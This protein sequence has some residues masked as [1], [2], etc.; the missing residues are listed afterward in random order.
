MKYLLSVIS[1]IIGLTSVWMWGPSNAHVFGA[2][3]DPG[4]SLALVAL[5]DSTKGGEWVHSWNLSAPVKEWYGVTLDGAGHKV[6]SLN[7]GNNGLDGVIPQAIGRLE[8]L[9][10]LRMPGNKLK[11][12]LP[13]SLTML[14]NLRQLI[15]YDNQ[16]EGS[17]PDSMQRMLS[18]KMISLINNKLNQALPASLGHL[19]QLEVLILSNNEIPGSIPESFSALV[20]LRTCNLSN[21]RLTGVLP[22]GTGQMTDLQE[23][24]LS[25]NQI[26]GKVPAS[27]AQ[28]KELRY[29]WLDHNRFMDSF[30]E[31]NLPELISLKLENNRFT[32]LPDLSIMPKLHDTAPNGVDVRHNQLS[33]ED[34][35]PNLALVDS[36]SRF[37]YWPQDTI[38][39]RDT[40][41]LTVG[42]AFRYKLPF[43]DTLSSNTYKWYKYKVQKEITRANELVFTKV[44]YSDE[45]EYHCEVSNSLLDSVKLQAYAFTLKIKGNTGCGD[46]PPADEC[47]LAKVQCSLNALDTYCAQTDQSRPRE[48]FSFCG[49]LMTLADRDW[50]AF[51]AGA[52]QARIRIT[53]FSCSSEPG[54]GIVALVFEDCSLG[55]PISCDTNCTQSTI[56]LNLTNLTVG[57]DYYLLI[58]GCE[59]GCYYQISVKQGGEGVELPEPGSIRGQDSICDHSA[60]YN[61]TLDSAIQGAVKYE[62]TVGDEAPSY[63][64]K[65]KLNTQWTEAGIFHLCVRGIGICDTTA[66][67]CRTVT[68]YPELKYENLQI[69]TVNEKQKYYVSF[70][71]TGGTPPFTVTGSSGVYNAVN[72]TFSSDLIDC[73]RP[74]IV[75][76][77]DANG[78]SLSVTGTEYCSCISEAGTLSGKDTITACEGGAF[79]VFHSNNAILDSNDIGVF[80]WYEMVKRGQ[81]HNIIEISD[82]GVFHYNEQL[83]ELNKAYRIQYVVASKTKNGGIDWLD[84]C[85]D[86]TPAKILL[87]RS[88]PHAF[89]GADTSVCFGNFRLNARFSSQGSEGRWQFAGGPDTPVI[90]RYKDSHTE[91]Q[92]ITPGTYQFYWIEVQG[93]CVDGDTVQVEVRP[94]LSFEV[95]GAKALCEGVESTLRVTPSFR[96]YRWSTGDSTRTITVSKPGFYGITVTDD[97]ACTATKT[98]ELKSKQGPRPIIL[99]P[100]RG[101][102]GDTLVLELNQSYPS[103]Q[104]ST[105][106]TGSKAYITQ[107]GIICVTVTDEDGCEGND[108]T[109]LE[110]ATSTTIFLRPELCFG[111]SILVGEQVF[112]DSGHYEVILPQANRNGC[113]STVVLDIHTFPEIYLSDTLLVHDDGSHNGLINVQI[114]GGKPPYIYQWDTGS[115]SPFIKNLTAGTYI[116]SVTDANNCTQTFEFVI[117]DLSAG[118]T[119]VIDPGIQLDFYPSVVKEGQTTTLRYRASSPVKLGV[120]VHALSGK[121]MWKTSIDALPSVQQLHIP[122]SLTK[123]VYLLS[124]TRDDKVID[125]RRWI[126]E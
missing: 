56:D 66:S 70:R 110:F 53:P 68:V 25:N 29:L 86:T 85:L 39:I 17:F 51:R 109:Q 19:P 96:H 32:G 42:E 106:D 121:T 35:L 11:G 74:Y 22:S 1:G 104:W 34:L 5:Y 102:T 14:A 73:G 75:G 69:E 33:F 13:D 49:R 52:A 113:D 81:F 90:V 125:T 3:I 58:G 126:V 95:E 98:Y 78:C 9:A 47:Y 6:V 57:Q 122:S 92:V 118:K 87:Y 93:S 55:T 77:T 37:D 123:G 54:S 40:F 91:V 46:P 45:G 4:D 63:T 80:I 88:R 18:L 61:Y 64:L 27:I 83:V 67:S 112:R 7:L 103:Y 115:K 43:D 89:G 108:C 41:Y 101:C 38:N 72:R 100:T 116:L 105:G 23:F 36:V 99:G 84:P 44:G 15:L 114:S 16:I 12:A 65:P 2:T 8:G 24:F 28:L 119:P 76:V 107:G 30:P 71:I 48:V 117:K 59:G 31:I 50:F 21:N 111:D 20:S 124:V 26:S 62:W 10:T 79:K 120:S 94:P 97:E 82:N 60:F